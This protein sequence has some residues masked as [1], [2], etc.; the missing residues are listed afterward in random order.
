MRNPIIHIGYPKTGSSWFQDNFYPFVGNYN[1]FDREE[2]KTVFFKSD[3]HDFVSFCKNNYLNNIIICEE[4]II[5]INMSEIKKAEKIKA[6]FDNPII[7]VF[8]RNQIK[9][10]ESKYSQ[11]I[12]FGGSLKFNSL[13]NHIIKIN[14]ISQWD[15]YRHLQTYI[16]IFSKENVHIYLFEDF[17]SDF[18][19]FIRNYINKYNFEIDDNKINYS[20][21]NKSYSSPIIKLARITNQFSKTRIGYNRPWEPFVFHIPLLHQAS[22][23]FYRVINTITPYKRFSAKKH[24]DNATYNRLC[25]YFKEGN[26]K[27]SEEYNLDFKKYNYP[28]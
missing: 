16:N 23:V 24:L 3:K 11:Y 21:V 20:K 7:I 1:Y 6:S 17:V 4:E 13:I 10:L 15:Y 18:D 5:N 28:M 14:K 8:I 22:H 19:T 27:L 2:F 9:L 25:D 26:K 12:K